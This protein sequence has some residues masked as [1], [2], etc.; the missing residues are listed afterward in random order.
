MVLLYED[1]SYIHAFQA[2]RATWAEV[3]KQKEIP[4]YGHHTS[5]TLFG[6]VNALDGE[7]FCTQAAQCNVQTF[8]SFLEKTLDLYANKYIVIVLDN[9]RIH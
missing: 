3:E 7:F 8:Y 5:V 1:E 9:D 4:T 2:L 6:M